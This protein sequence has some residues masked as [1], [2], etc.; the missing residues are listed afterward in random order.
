[1]KAAANKVLKKDDAPPETIRLR[2]DGNRVQKAATEAAE[3]IMNP[4]PPWLPGFLFDQSWEVVQAHSIEGIWPTRGEMWD[5]LVETWRLANLLDEHLQHSAI[6][7]FI[8]VHSDADSPKFFSDM[9]RDLKKLRSRIG[10]ALKSP[11]LVDKNGKLR[12]GRGKP[13]LPNTQPAKYRCAA[14]IVEVVDFLYPDRS[15]RPPQRKIWLVADNLW[16]AWFKPD[17]WGPD[18]LTGWKDYF[19][20]VDETRLQSFRAQVRRVLNITAHRHAQLSEDK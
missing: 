12:K 15:S 5:D 18:H 10:Q 3:A 8:T 6:I 19:K 14:I 4:V 16:K 9:A 11:E 1:M 7:G 13:L 20:A 17:S 2:P